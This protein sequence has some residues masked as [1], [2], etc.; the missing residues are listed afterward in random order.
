MSLMQN[1]LPFDCYVFSCRTLFLFIQRLLST[2]KLHNPV[3]CFDLTL[4]AAITADRCAIAA[5]K[6]DGEDITSITQEFF[7]EAFFLYERDV[8][9]TK[10]QYS[11]ISKLIGTLLSCR[12]LN[13]NEYEVFI[14]KA[15]QYSAR[16]LKKVDQCK[17]VMMCSRLFDAG[18][19]EVSVGSAIHKYLR[20]VFLNGL[21]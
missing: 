10:D 9:D 19:D 7:T 5:K 2:L 11:I 4:Q 21:Y 6:C 13:T 14:T 15:T 20:A 12:A 1:V 3:L 17:A 18:E 16:L 8:S